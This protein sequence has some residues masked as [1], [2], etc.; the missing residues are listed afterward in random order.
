ML[1][2]HRIR[3]FVAVHDVAVAANAHKVQ[4][5]TAQAHEDAWL[6]AGAASILYED[7]ITH[8]K[9]NFQSPSG[10]ARGHWLAWP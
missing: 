6:L 1:T 7:D 8:S 4:G 5:P 9:G 10:C 2:A 3:I